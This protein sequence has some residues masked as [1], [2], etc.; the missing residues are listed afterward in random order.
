MNT[1][2]TPLTLK[3]ETAKDL[4]TPNPLSIR[5]F[6]SLQEAIT[7]MR[8]NE[9][10]AIPVVD[11][12]NRPKGVLSQTDIVQHQRE[13]VDYIHA[14]PEYY[15]M[16]E[17][18]LDSG[19]VFLDGFQLQKIEKS[20]VS[21]VMTPFVVAIAPDMPVKDVIDTMLSKK[22]HRLF[23]INAEGGLEG[24]ISMTDFLKNLQ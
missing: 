4:M 5:T 16:V 3:A 9:L 14:S 6:L 23:V 8:E 1:T 13:K 15:Q 2:L 12:E 19:E 11:K 20:L 24:V 7:F 10:L 18:K 22:L 21:E 17:L